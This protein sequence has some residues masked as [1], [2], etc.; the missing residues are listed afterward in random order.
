MSLSQTVYYAMPVPLQN[1]LVSGYGYYLRHK[2]QPSTYHAL[3]DKIEQS[4][5]WSLADMA[6]YQA[7]ALQ[8]TLQL[9]AESV[10]YYRDRWRQAG[11]AVADIQ[12]PADLVRLPVLPK[13]DARRRATEMRTASGRAYWTNHTSGSTGTP[14]V[15]QLDEESYVLVHALLEAHESGC[16]IAEGDLRATFAGRMVQPADHLGPPFWRY[17]RAL[18][19]LLFSSY[20]MTDRTLPLYLEELA[21]WQPAELIGYPSAIAILATHILEA[22]QQGRIRP[23]VVITNSETLFGWQRQAIEEA[24]GCPVRDYYGSAEAVIFAAQCREGTYHFDPLIGIAEIVDDQNRP[25]PPGVPGRLLA[26]TLTNRVMPLVRYE[27]GDLATRAD[28]PCRCGSSHPGVREI[29]GREDDVIMTP[30]GRIVGRIDHIFKGIVGIREC[31][32]IQEA[33]DLVRLML[34]ADA[35]F[36]AAQEALV[37]SNA[38]SRLGNAVRLELLRVESIPRT[39]NGKFRGVVSH[40]TT[41]TAVTQERPTPSAGHKPRSQVGA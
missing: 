38:H 11:V 12:S 20:H 27:V 28:G 3:R 22:G 31:Q 21:R 34:V 32:V 35:G 15:V 18:R 30:D 4:R 37:R 9:C 29:I 2:R 1:L 39:A 8:R 6:G 40:L 26:T 33:P 23:R 5:Q 24:L 36:D 13:D 25:V 10:P 41:V 19:Q 7:A 17:N 16:G 14:V